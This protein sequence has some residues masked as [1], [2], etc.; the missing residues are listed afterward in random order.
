[1]KIIERRNRVAKKRYR[2]LADQLQSSDLKQVV[3]GSETKLQRLKDHIPASL[4]AIWDD[5]RVMAN[6]VKS[7]ANGSYRQIPWRSL[8]AISAALLYF[9]TPI[10]ALPDIIPMAGYIDDAFIFK[11][12]FDLVREDLEA[13][14]RWQREQQEPDQ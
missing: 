4:A 13:Y 11:L 10:D 8:A 14:K 5:I 1:M 3:E 7:Y 6:L 9:I 12:V 2:I